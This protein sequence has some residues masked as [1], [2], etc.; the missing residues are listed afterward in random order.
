MSRID[1][2]KALAHLH[3]YL[4]QELTPEL[5]VEVRQHLERCRDCFSHVQFEE[6]FFLKIETCSRRQT[7]PE[8]LRA[9]IMA[10]LRA[11]ARDH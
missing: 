8:Q 1:C 6:S 4:K 5:V 3:D 7:C 9:R 11:E 10:A 2:E